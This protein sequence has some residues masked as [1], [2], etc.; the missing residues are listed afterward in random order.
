[1]DVTPDCPLIQNLF[2]KR[3]LLRA[4]DERH[5]EIRTALL[6]LGGGTAGASGGG[7]AIALNRFGLWECFDVVIGVSTGAGI[8]AYGGCGVEQAMIGTS[9]YPEECSRPAF[10][11]W[12][13]D[14]IAD[15]G[16]IA[17]LLRRGPKRLD[18]EA[19]IRSR[20]QFFVAVSDWESGEGL[21]LDAK[22]ALPDPIAAVQ[23]STALRGAFERPV[24]VNGRY[25]ADGALDPLPITKVVRRFQPTDLFV[26]ANCTR[27]Q[28]AI[29]RPSR[30]EQLLW[31]MDPRFRRVPQYIRQLVLGRYRRYREGFEEL[32]RLAANGLNAGIIWS[33]AEV[34]VFC[35]NAARLR[36]AAEMST[37]LTLQLLA[38]AEKKFRSG[39]SAPP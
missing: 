19:L 7:V 33:P 11:N 6:I 39:G 4:G 29:K 30:V 12:R 16:F 36:L 22:R 21:F 37:G 27:Q 32:S 28:A 3:E 1:M 23:A 13:R 31:H 26:I 17:S 34:G 14:P 5:R 38:A 9:I 20:P 8:G 15:V 2:R 35:R 24:E 25:C 10:I 18:V